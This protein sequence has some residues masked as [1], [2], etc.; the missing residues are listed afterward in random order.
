MIIETDPPLLRILVVWGGVNNQE[1]TLPGELIFLCGVQR[2]VSTQGQG[3]R[4]KGALAWCPLRPR[5]PNLTASGLRVPQAPHQ[6]RRVT[7]GFPQG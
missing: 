7:D 4:V 2:R 1:T 5:E 6:V 3:A